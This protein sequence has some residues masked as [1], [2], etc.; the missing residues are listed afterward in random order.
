MHLLG[1]DAKESPGVRRDPGKQL[2]QI[3]GV[4]PIQG[5]PQAIIIEH[6][7]GDSRSQQM[8]ERL[9]REELRD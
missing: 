2:C 9:V 3:V 8:F 6:L 5:A 7:G 4:Q 1:F